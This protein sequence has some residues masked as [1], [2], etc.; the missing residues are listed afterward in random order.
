MAEPVIGESAA[1]IALEVKS[2]AGHPA[3][4]STLFFTEMWE[5]FS[6]Y[7]MRAL[8]ILYLTAAAVNGGAGLDTAKAASIYGWYTF[9]VYAASIP[10]G[11]IA[12]RFLGQYRS[13]LLGG[14]L[15]AGGHFSL[16]FGNVSAFYGGLCLIIVGTGLLKPNISAMVGSLYQEGDPRRDGGFSIFYMGI[17]LGAFI[18]PLVCG[19]LGQKVGWHWG[20][21]AAGIGMTL[22]LIQYVLGRQRLA[23]ALTRIEEKKEVRNETAAAAQGQRFWFTPMEW[24]RIGAIGIFFVFSAL[25]WAAFEQGGSSLNLFADR[26]TRASLF[27][28]RFPSTWFQSLNSLYILM[29]APMF[30]WLWVRLRKH[31]PSSPVKFSVGLL[32]VGLGF[33]LLVPASLISGPEQKLVSPFWLAGV[34]FLH[35]VGEL[36][37]SPVGLSVVTKLAPPQIVGRM[38]GLWFLST[39]LGNKVGG[40]V[41][42]FFDTLPLPQLFGAVFATTTAAA[43]LLAILIRPVRRLMSGVH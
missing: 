40:W 6:Y 25:F 38:M 28:F 19:T 33:L 14:I 12:D 16:A 24:K 5:R 18:A 15:I 21:G 2:W 11:W 7:G 39:A 30:A 27:D 13:V 36:C 37:L 41:A 17:N 20:F 23:S 22:G 42:G 4:L 34:Y 1:P 35:T 43:I 26:L 31:E 8:L 32:F 3:G 10:G 29:L 9:G